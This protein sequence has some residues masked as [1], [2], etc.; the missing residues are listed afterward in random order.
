M[1]PNTA[2]ESIEAEIETTDTIK[3]VDER[4]WEELTGADY[5]ERAY[6]WYK[7]V[8]D[9]GITKMHYLFLRENERLQ[10]AACSF[11]F[12]ERLQTPPIETTILE[13]GTPLGGSRAFF[14]STPDHTRVLI[15]GLEEIRK[16]EKAK[17]LSILCF[18]KEEYD[19][20]SPQ[21][22]GFTRF[23]IQGSTYLDLNFADFD[24]YLDSLDAEARRS[25]RK[26]LNRA[27]KRWKI[28]SVVTSDLLPWRGT[29]CRLQK[30]MCEQHKDDQWL[31]TEKFYDALEKNLKE[32]TELTLFFKDDVPIVFGLSFNSPEISQHKFAG[33]DPKYRQYQAYFLLYYE[34]IKKAIERKQKRIYFGST[35]YA[36]K[37]KIGCKI[38]P[39][40]GFM[41]MKNPAFNLVFKSYTVIHRLLDKNP[42]FSR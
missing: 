9:S 33:V 32:R 13:V 4:E 24:D 23:P 39:S 34:G 19:A 28:K 16:K 1:I 29:A 8:E 3:S 17:G 11:L 35:T 30:Y 2:G 15:K 14:S 22:E 40:F 7:T 41:R 21:L 38:E 25:I 10:A 20:I 36:F 6:K 5:V 42:L 12:R 37:E 31:L 18:K 26:T 27:K